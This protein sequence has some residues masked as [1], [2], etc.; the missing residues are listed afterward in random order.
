MITSARL[1]FGQLAIVR[2]VEDVPR[3]RWYEPNLSAV[4]D[5]PAGT[6][7]A[8]VRGALGVLVRRH[9]SLRTT[10][11][12]AGAG[13][14]EQLL[15]PPEEPVVRVE[16]TTDPR[17]DPRTVLRELSRQAFSLVREPPWRATVVTSGTEPAHLVLVSHHVVADGH[18][19]TVLE[20][21]FFTALAG[22]VDGTA[23]GPGVILAHERSPAGLRR[24]E[25]ALAYWTKTVA[26]MPPPPVAGEPPYVQAT[27]VSAT[28]PAAARQVA[29][30]LRASVPN[31]VLAAFCTALL[32]LTDDDRLAVRLLSSNRFDPYRR[33]IVTSMNQWVPI[34]V[35][36][37]PQSDPARLV[38]EI[39]KRAMVA[40][41][42][43]VYD[44]DEVFR[45]LDDAGYRPGQYD[46]LWSFNFVSHRP[47]EPVSP[48]VS[49]ASTAPED[50]PIHWAA[51]FSSVGPRCYLRAIEGADLRLELRVPIN[52]SELAAELIRR[53]RLFLVEAGRA[54]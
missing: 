32:G 16:R 14:P 8:A 46:S 51:P 42:H 17:I 26:E 37:S 5:L 10:Y 45:L 52:R 43:G 22:T 1:T 24:G 31:V 39:G 15:H 30:R 35:D 50:E 36:R 13:G 20:R 25:A 40:Y 18:A 6:T 12:L 9:E 41:A 38:R 7:M 48:A 53:M 34:L 33:D 19:L 29:A 54:G 23:T 47:R 27:L 3:Q 44:V 11:D 28:L 49:A 2:D 4:W 21:D